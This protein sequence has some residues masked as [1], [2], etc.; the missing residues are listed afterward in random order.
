[1]REVTEAADKLAERDDNV[2]EV[3]KALPVLDIGDFFGEIGG[4]VWEA[5]R[6]ADA[7]VAHFFAGLNVID[8]DEEDGDV[9]PDIFDSI[10][11]E[12][13]G[14]M[15]ALEEPSIDGDAEVEGDAL[16]TGT[17]S[18]AVSG[19]NPLESDENVDLTDLLGESFDL[20]GLLDL[21][22]GEDGNSR[23]EGVSDLEVAL[24]SVG[25]A[26]E[27]S[28]ELDSDSEGSNSRRQD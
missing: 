14:P 23:E 9:L 6:A 28:T 7:E 20:H 4:E 10:Y 8:D 15:N 5:E 11:D 27:V 26:S 24:I 25:S 18:S 13:G 12:T 19:V 1:M 22:D 16:S 17:A 21:I 3:G 2:T